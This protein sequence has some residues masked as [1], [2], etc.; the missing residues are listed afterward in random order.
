M[1]DWPV[2]GPHLIAEPTRCGHIKAFNESRI[3]D[4]SSRAAIVIDMF[5]CYI[6]SISFDLALNVI[7]LYVQLSLA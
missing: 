5:A 7:I 6:R 4:P 1:V 3:S 2:A